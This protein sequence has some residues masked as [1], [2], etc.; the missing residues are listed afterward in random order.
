MNLPMNA[1]LGMGM[2]A[3]ILRRRLRQMADVKA[4]TR[5]TSRWPGRRRHV[6]V[7]LYRRAL[8]VV[9]RF[10]I[11]GRVRCAICG[12]RGAEFRPV[13]EGEWVQRNVLCPSCDSVQRH[14]LV[15]L[16]LADV[17]ASKSSTV[18]WTAPEACLVPTITERFDGAITVDIEMP[19]VD[20][21][22][23][24]AA[25]PIPD[26]ALG[27]VISVD[28]LEHVS[29]DR[30]VLV[31]FG[32]VLRA[33]GIVLLHVPMLWSETVEYGFADLADHGH[34]RGYGPD[35]VARIREAG[36]A[37]ETIVARDWSERDRHR[38]GLLDWDVVFL[39]RKVTA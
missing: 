37:V 10:G 35:V 18:L 29:D 30:R 7:L 22:A 5:A 38:L 17:T 25:I 13:V 32:R 1:Q 16:V 12:W 9:E 39:L 24:L 4:T 3:E 28:V 14:R 6:A 33:D 20:L 8:A 26:G 23:D 34:R 31:E 36:F 21:H 19:G 15:A 11:R 2:D 27:A